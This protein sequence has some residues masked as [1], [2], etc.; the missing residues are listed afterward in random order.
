ML[1][2]N[3]KEQFYWFH[4]GR[5]SVSLSGGRSLLSLPNKFFNLFMFTC[6]VP[7]SAWSIVSTWEMLV[8]SNSLLFVP[9]F[10]FNLFQ[11]S[12]SFLLNVLSIFCTILPLGN[13][14]IILF[15]LQL[16]LE[17]KNL[18][19]LWVQCPSRIPCWIYLYRC[20]W[21]GLKVL[22]QIINM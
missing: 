1:W 10:Y 6:L 14:V 16:N 3:I 18:D 15:I 2:F 13:M 9:H 7:N 21:K 12:N 22:C 11:L 17:N 20:G 19:I 5:L 4:L 8:E